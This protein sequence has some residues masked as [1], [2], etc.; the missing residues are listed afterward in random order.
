MPEGNEERKRCE[1]SDEGSIGERGFLDMNWRGM[2]K[3]LVT[4]A[5]TYIVSLHEQTAENRNST[6]LLL[7]TA[8]A[9]DIV[10]QRNR[11]RSRQ[12]NFTPSPLT[13]RSQSVAT[14]RRR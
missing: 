5:D 11:G 2:A 7:A 13:H 3:Q 1:A 10:V 4:S 14:G 6:I 9:I 12:K 8:L